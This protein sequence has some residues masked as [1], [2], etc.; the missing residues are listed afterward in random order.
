MMKFKFASSFVVLPLLLCSMAISSRGQDVVGEAQE[1]VIHYQDTN[2]LADPVALLQKR[3]AEGAATLEFDPQR[4]YLDS[5]LKELRVPV[6]S[7]VLVFS[8]TSS[9]DEQTSPKTPRAVY[10]TDELSVA[11]VPGGSVIDLASVDPKRGPIFYTLAQRADG[12][13]QFA[14]GADCMQCHLGNKTLQVPGLL[15]RSVYASADGTPLA[16]VDGF[17]SGHNSPVS[18]RWGGWY[19]TGA[20]S[21]GF[22]LGNLVVTNLNYPEQLDIS[23]GGNIADLRG[24]FDTSGYPSPYSDIVALLV[25]EHQVRMQNLVTAANY[26]TRYALEELQIEKQ[27]G[28]AAEST[29]RA[30]ERTQQRIALAGERL[31]EY[32]LFRDEAVLNGPIEGI[33]G[34]AGEFERAGPRDSQGRSLRQLDLNKRLLRYPCSF[35]IYSRAFDALPQQMKDY[36]WLR[37]EQILTQADRS[38]TYATLTA[39]ECKE[40]LQILRDTKP[41]FAAWMSAHESKAVSAMTSHSVSPNASEF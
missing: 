25:L 16:K 5:L 38:P 2:G 31:L 35:L 10:F 12:P 28:I 9:Q 33:S 1:R 4:G 20:H 19:V 30:K 6:S 41:E 26:E 7:Q 39:Q 11:W 18:Q 22:H 36:L 34:F 17:V 21:G 32:L 3:L 15:V 8:K 23:A 40:V 24:R 27:T 14:R 37:L 13:P 29:G